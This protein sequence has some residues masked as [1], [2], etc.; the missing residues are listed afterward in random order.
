MIIY[1]INK[2]YRMED[3]K[4]ASLAISYLNKQISLTSLTEI[5]QALSRL[6]QNETQKMMLIE[7]N[8]DYIFKVI[9]PPIV[10]E[11]KSKPKRA[12]ICLMGSLL[13]LMLAIF[14]AIILNSYSQKS[15]N[16]S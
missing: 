5:K 3:K 2:I 15:L 12:I 10:E 11:I 9:D 16:K 13:G 8:E 14:I 6:I 1:E 4:K 7:A